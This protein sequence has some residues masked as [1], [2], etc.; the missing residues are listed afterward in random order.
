VHLWF[1]R[2]IPE[3]AEADVDQPERWVIDTNVAA[4]SRAITTIA[5]VA[6]LEFAEK[7]PRLS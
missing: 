7:T 5:D 1:E 6:A 4:A 2:K 3:S